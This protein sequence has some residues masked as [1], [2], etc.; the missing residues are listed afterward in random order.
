MFD[1]KQLLDQF[2]GGQAPAGG[3]GQA[4]P[5]GGGVGGLLSSPGAKGLAGGAVAGALFTYY[6]T[7]NGFS[8]PGMDEMAKQFNPPAAVF[9]QLTLL[10][11]MAGPLAVFLFTLLSAVYPALRLHWL[12]PVEAM[13]SA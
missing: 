5:G 9:P 13:R 4:S 3:E 10:T 11:V 7:V 6:F 2:M 12:H 8:Y 1:A